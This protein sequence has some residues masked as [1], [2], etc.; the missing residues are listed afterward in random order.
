[1]SLDREERVCDF[2]PQPYEC[3][4]AIFVDKYYKGWKAF[5]VCFKAVSTYI[6][7]LNPD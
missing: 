3:G 5:F 4:L 7:S 1:M 6:V 2:D